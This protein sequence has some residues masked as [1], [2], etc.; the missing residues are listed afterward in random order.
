MEGELS[1][2]YRAS[3]TYAV[4]VLSAEQGRLKHLVQ[5]KESTAL[6]IGFLA[7]AMQLIRELRD[8]LKER[9]E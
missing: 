2:R 1:K 6:E 5:P 8:D 7:T 4:G 3:L 9:G